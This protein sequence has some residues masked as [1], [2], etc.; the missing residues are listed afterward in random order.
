MPQML[1]AGDFSDDTNRHLK[2]ILSR[3]AAGDLAARDELIAIASERM[4]GIAHR[5]LRTFPTVQRW[6][7]TDDI[8]QNAAMRLYRALSQITPRDPRGLIGL[9]AVQV[10]RELLDLARRHTG[11]ES[12]GA[13]HETNVQRIDGREM[14]KIDLAA[15]FAEPADRLDRWTRLHEAAETLPDEEREIF[16]L[17]WYMGLKQEEI[18]SLR[19]C[20]VRTVKRRWE[21]AKTMIKRAVEGDPPT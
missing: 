16:H 3:L 19:S 1:V 14:P 12:Y 11:P 4:R 21:S 15:D 20:S 9:A 2:D 7:E 5:M 18:A 6:D 13:N 10:R 17:V 8:V